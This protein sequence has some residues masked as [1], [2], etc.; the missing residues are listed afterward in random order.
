MELIAAFYL[1]ESNKTFVYRVT[2]WRQI[3]ASTFHS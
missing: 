1:Q 2:P 3:T